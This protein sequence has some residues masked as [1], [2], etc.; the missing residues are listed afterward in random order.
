[1]SDVEHLLGVCWPSVCL[2]WR[3][4]YLELQKIG[5]SMQPKFVT[6]QGKK[7]YSQ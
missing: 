7:N 3:N 4:V 5:Q 6:I 1:M 2:P